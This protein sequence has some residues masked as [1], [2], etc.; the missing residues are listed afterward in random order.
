MPRTSFDTLTFFSTQS[1][2]HVTIHEPL[3]LNGLSVDLSM[4]SLSRLN[5]F[6]GP[7]LLY[8]RLCTKTQYSNRQSESAQ[9]HICVRFSRRV[10]RL[11]G[12]P[13][14]PRPRSRR[15]V[16]LIDRPRL[17]PPRR[18]GVQSVSRGVSYCFVD[19]A[20][21]ARFALRT[22]ELEYTVCRTSKHS[23]LED[24]ACR[25]EK[26]QKKGISRLR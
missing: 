17:I 23:A 25:T 8:R 11:E 10:T 14:P 20:P 1:S 21:R 7:C 4:S 6:E 16:I 12:S 15:L 3:A 9:H 18:G 5:L 22:N 26:E 13:K 19:L 24:S 2:D